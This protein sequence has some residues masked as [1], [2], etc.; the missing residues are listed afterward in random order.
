[1]STGAGRPS[2][3]VNHGCAGIEVLQVAED[4][5]GIGGAPGAHSLGAGTWAEQL[6]L[7]DQRDRGRGESQALQIRRHRERE[8]RAA[9]GEGIPALDDAHLV[10]VR[11]QHL[12][13]HFAPAGGVGGDQHAPLERPQERI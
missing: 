2:D 6:R 10:V 3:S 12:V 1:M 11:A 7:G 13:Q 8:T 9:G 4:G 5:L